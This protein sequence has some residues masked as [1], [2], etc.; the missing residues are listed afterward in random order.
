MDK[1]IYEEAQVIMSSRRRRAEAENERRIAEVNQSIPEIREVN[2]TLINTGREL[3]RIISER[4]SKEDINKKIEQLKQYNLGAQD[5]SRQLLVSR[6]FP[7][8]Y[9]DMHYVC[10]KCSDTGYYNNEYCE[11]FKKLCGK[12]SAEELNKTANLKLSSF[13]TFDLSYYTG[14]DR[15][16]MEKILDF[17]RQYAEQFNEH[18]GSIFMFGDTGL[19]KTHLSL[20]AANRILE[21][22]Y[23]VVYDS[24]VN[25]LRKIE[26]EHF[27][28]E[29]SSETINLVMN[30]DLLILDD[31]GTE[32]QTPFYSSTIYNIINTRLNADRPTIIS[33]NLDF[34]GISRRYEK[35]VVS[36]I[37]SA[38]TCLE[39][40]GDD[41][42]LKRRNS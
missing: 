34:D 37:V 10:P 18:S 36:R 12:L 9:L 1:S 21:R 13:S 26:Q 5:M 25:I 41:I 38:Y 40:K 22:G 8:D 6:G 32:Y 2:N 28:R 39:F 20:S 15:R 35:R 30:T 42:R 27:S 19:G 7:A 16:T 11:C 17:T 3:I 31:L 23:G 29:H 33:T 14:A 4:G 24:A